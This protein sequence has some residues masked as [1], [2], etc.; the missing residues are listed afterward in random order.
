MT[1]DILNLALKCGADDYEGCYEFCPDEIEAFYRA[2]FNA[3][4]SE[5]QPKLTKAEETVK[6]RTKQTAEV[7]LRMRE[8]EAE[9]RG[10][11]ETIHFMTNELKTYRITVIEPGD[12]E[13]SIVGHIV[14]SVRRM[15]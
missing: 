5:S 2:A 3:G 4:L 14:K 8:L 1:D 15:R 7:T 12:F 6:I 10:L 11:R 13:L 9:N